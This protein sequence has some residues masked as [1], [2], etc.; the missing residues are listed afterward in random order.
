MKA[1][2]RLFKPEYVY[3][4]KQLCLRVVR[5]FRRETSFEDL[6][7]PW[8]SS[9]YVHPDHHVGRAIWHLGLYD[10]TVT[11]ALWRLV[12]SGELAVDIGANIGYMT[13]VMAFRVGAGGRVVAF[14]PQPAVYKKLVRNVERW[15][16][17]LGALIDTYQVATSD[18]AG[19]ELLGVPDDSEENSGLASLNISPDVTLKYHVPVSR[20]DDMLDE[21]VGVL[22][23]DVEGYEFTALTGAIDLLRNH[24]I[25]DV[26]FEEHAVYPTPTTRLLES[27]GYTVFNLGANLWGLNINAASE[28]TTHRP[29]EPRSCL[30]TINPSRALKRMEERG[31]QTL[32]ESRSQRS[33]VRDQ[34]SEVRDQQSAMR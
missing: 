17:S 2:G 5:G 8:G 3:R 24:R 33:E 7:L 21:R 23:I 26:I 14:E 4:P 1:I 18:H 6:R 19:Q 13:G 29:W 28:K 15:K 10:L 9:I 30:A 25:R 31:W 11:E 27:L 32:S 22:K 16:A 20:L 12:D 34:K